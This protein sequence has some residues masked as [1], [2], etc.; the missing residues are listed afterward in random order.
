MFEQIQNVVESIDKFNNS[1]PYIDAVV[2]CLVLVS[3]ELAKK[4]KP[5]NMKIANKWLTLFVGIFVIF[6]YLFALNS[7]GELY[8]ENFPKYVVSY[9]TANAFYSHLLKYLR[10]WAKSSNDVEKETS[11]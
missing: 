6:V 8:K 9:L 4:Y 10:K 1:Q 7:A 2:V 3:A 11:N 5:D